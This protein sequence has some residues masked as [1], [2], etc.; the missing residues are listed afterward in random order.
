VKLR[1]DRGA[2]AVEMAIVIP[3]LLMILFGI[4][5]FGRMYN[6]QVTLTDAAREGARAAAAGDSADN[7]VQAVTTGMNPKVTTDAVSYTDS[8]NRT[9][10]ACGADVTAKVTVRYTF[11]Y[12]TPF[13][14]IA[15][16]FPGAKFGGNVAMTATAS[17][18]CAT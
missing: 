14:A 8:A 15:G 1:A 2:A 4:I 10:T 7:R 18:A 11:S 17:I 16:M 5:D 9:V 13:A 12:V 3:V 6:A